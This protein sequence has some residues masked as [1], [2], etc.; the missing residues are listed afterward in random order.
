MA[1]GLN[2]ITKTKMKD[3]TLHTSQYQTASRLVTQKTP[4]KNRMFYACYIIFIQYNYKTKVYQ[5]F[6]AYFCSNVMNTLKLQSSWS[7]NDIH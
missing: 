1:P 2:Y 5:M 6:L 3:V 4:K 7:L